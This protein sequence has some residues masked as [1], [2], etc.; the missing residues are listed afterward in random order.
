MENCWKQTW[1]EKTKQS[2]TNRRTPPGGS[3]DFVLKPETYESLLHLVH[4]YVLYL[5]CCGHNAHTSLFWCVC[6][7][8]T[9][10]RPVACSGQQWGQFWPQSCRTAWCSAWHRGLVNQQLTDLLLAEPR[11]QQQKQH[12]TRWPASRLSCNTEKV[13]ILIT[14]TSIHHPRT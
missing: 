5:S 11:L 8:I 6:L 2:N 1:K 13:Q 10:L 14:N 9:N 4:M 3:V 7:C 12:W